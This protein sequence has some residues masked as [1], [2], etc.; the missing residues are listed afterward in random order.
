LKLG[1]VIHRDVSAGSHSFKEVF[2]G[3]EKVGA[4]KSTFGKD[5]GKVLFDLE[6]EIEEGRGYMRINDKKGS[7]MVNSK[8]LK[9][10]ERNY[11]YLDVVH[12]LVHIRQLMEGKE[13][14]DKKYAYVDRPTELEAYGVAVKEARRIGLSEK[15]IVDYLKVDWVSDED[16]KRFLGSLGVK[17]E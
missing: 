12:E 9:A 14:W 3:F 17:A 11:I 16:F 13:L 10:G 8:Y 6:V 1:V 2:E 4:V 15:K 7:V 5:C